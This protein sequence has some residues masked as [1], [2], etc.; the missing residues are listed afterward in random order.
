V[1]GEEAVEVVGRVGPVRLV[2][3][4]GVV[5]WVHGLVVVNLWRSPTDQSGE[6]STARSGS[7]ACLISALLRLFGPRINDI[8]LG[9]GATKTPR[10]DDSTSIWKPDGRI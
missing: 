1:F 5:R 10:T 3:R 9:P 6:W 8:L 7:S 4:V 2:R